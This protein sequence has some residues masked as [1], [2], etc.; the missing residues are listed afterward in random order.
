MTNKRDLIGLSF[1][2]VARR[3]LGVSMIFLLCFL[4]CSRAMLFAQNDAMQGTTDI[5]PSLQ[6]N[7]SDLPPL[8]GLSIGS[9]SPE[10]VDKFVKFI[11]EELAPAHFNLLVLLVDYNYAYESHPELRADNP[12]KKEDVR[13]ITAVCKKHNIKIVPQLSMFGHQSWEKS[14][15]KLLTVYPELDETPQFDIKQFGTSWAW[16]DPDAWLYCKSYCPLHPKV[17][18]ILFPMIDE[19]LTVFETDYF[20]AGMDEV[21]LIGS[22][23]CPRCKGKD[24]AELFAGEVNAIHEHLKK[25]NTRMM[26]WGDRLIDQTMTG[27][28]VSESSTFGTHR[29]ISLIPKDILICDWHY[30]KA[31]LT[32]V[33]FA[34]N[35]FDVLVCP[36]KNAT[37]AMQQLDDMLLF[38][39]RALPPMKEH[40]QGV[41]ET[42]WNGNEAFLKAYYNEPGAPAGSK[43]EAKTVKQLIERYK[44]K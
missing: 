11:D 3:C 12:L 5:A 25:H 18:Q 38:R 34:I 2:R 24:K 9:P 32:P 14:L 35:G 29:A 16:K 21:T 40:F 41:L 43:G 23:Q 22:P 4:F 15:G 28:H 19:L 6:Q 10:G 27:Q 37:V 1:A 30:G 20:H 44:N 26:I 42:I 33:Y 36:W 13:K 8:R 39:Q 31:P 17:H 7:N